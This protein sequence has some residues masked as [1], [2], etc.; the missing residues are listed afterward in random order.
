MLPFKHSHKINKK[1][2]MEIQFVKKE[3]NPGNQDSTN[4]DNHREVLVLS[5]SFSS[6]S[7]SNPFVLS[8]NNL[9]YSVKAG[10]K[11]VFPFHGKT[12]TVSPEHNNKSKSILKDVSGEAREGEIMAILGASGSG[13]STLIDAL[14]NRIAK[15][16]LKG[17]VTLNGEFWSQVY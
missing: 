2:P 12:M 10:P 7:P 14:A 13:K 17:S 16:S 8:F 15:H 4:K 1:I 5:N 3:E 11:T 9:T 6:I